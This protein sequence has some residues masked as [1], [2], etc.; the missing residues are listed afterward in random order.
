MG[1]IFNRIDTDQDQSL[2]RAEVKQMV[3]NAK[4]GGGIFGG[5]KVGQATDAFMKMLDTDQDGAVTHEEIQTQFL[6]LMSKLP[7]D[8]DKTLPERAGEWFDRVDTSHDDRVTVDEA[9]AQL[10]VA[11]EGQDFADLKA[12]IGAKIAV[13]LVDESGNGTADRAEVQ[14]LAED[15]AAQ[16]QPEPEP[17]P[18]PEPVPEPAPVVA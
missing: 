14:S 5:I 6:A 13:Y 12:E 2:T 8:G 16:S 10:K 17:A 9:K 18:E 7:A 3:E 11:L 4:V 15:V 1:S